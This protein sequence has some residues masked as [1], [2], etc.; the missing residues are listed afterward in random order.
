MMAGL[1]ARLIQMVLA[2]PVGWLADIWGDL[3]L[4]G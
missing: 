1:A 3:T 2:V 4:K